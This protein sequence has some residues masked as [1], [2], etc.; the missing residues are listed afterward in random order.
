MILMSDIK[1]HVEE[2]TKKAHQG[3]P[4]AQRIFCPVGNTADNSIAITNI[5]HFIRF[6]TCSHPFY[7][8]SMEYMEKIPVLSFAKKVYRKLSF[9]YAYK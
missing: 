2:I 4:A 3:D 5:I 7:S 1:K 8:C 6:L 9:T